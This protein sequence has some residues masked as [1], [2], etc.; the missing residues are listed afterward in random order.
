MINVEVTP[1]Q[2][3]ALRSALRAKEGIELPGNQG[4]IETR[5]YTVEYRY[6]GSDTL[7]LAAT[8]KPFLGS[9]TL[10]EAA[11][12]TALRQNGFTVG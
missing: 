3:D 12:K 8:K 9:I 1:Q 6:N 10:C 4:E 7:S 2:L 5:G 11:I